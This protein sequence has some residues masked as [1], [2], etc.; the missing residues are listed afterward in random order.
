MSDQAKEIAAVFGRGADTYDRVIPFFTSFGERLVDEAGLVEGEHVLD[1]A[2]GRGA[3]LF[4]AARAVAP[5][6]RVLGID[7]SDEM[8]ALTSADIEQQGVGNASVR[9]M[10]AGHLDLEPESYDVALASFVLHLVP[11]PAAVAAQILRV[12]RPGGRC[13][14]SVPTGAGPD[15][16]FQF[17]VMMAYVPRAVRRPTMPFRPDFDLPGTLTEAGFETVRTVEVQIEFVFP[18][19]DRWWQWGWSHGMRS[20]FE[21]LPPADLDELRETLFSELA[22]RRTAAGIA[23]PQRAQFVVAGR[24]AH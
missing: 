13:A 2:C 4:P 23:M 16:D 24:P 22:R 3:T 7:L 18:D 20:F 15:W 5:T 17:R 10:D 8:I 9:V 6:G 21:V 1:V 12:L 19:E 14:A 11:D